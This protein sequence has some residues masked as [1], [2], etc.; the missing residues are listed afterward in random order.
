VIAPT[1]DSAGFENRP[2]FEAAFAGDTEQILYIWGPPDTVSYSADFG[3]TVDD[4]SGNLSGT[5]ALIGLV[6][7]PTA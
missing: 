3:A 5:G 4:R 2:A 6:G 1:A 7:G